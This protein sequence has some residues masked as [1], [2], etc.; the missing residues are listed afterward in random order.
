MVSI[1]KYLNLRDPNDRMLVYS[2]LILKKVLILYFIAI[3]FMFF[4]SLFTKSNNGK[5]IEGNMDWFKSDAQKR[6]EY[7]A[8]MARAALIRE[9]QE[10]E[11][12]RCLISTSANFRSCGPIYYF[13]EAHFKLGSDQSHAKSQNKFDRSKKPDRGQTSYA[14]TQISIY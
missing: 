2:L 13:P 10:R 11:R 9:L 14:N 4:V 8:L 3:I 1:L 6:R 5:I 7:E 12:Q